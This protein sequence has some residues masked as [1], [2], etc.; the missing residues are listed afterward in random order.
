VRTTGEIGGILLRRVERVRKA[1]R[2]EFVCGLRAV[3][4]AR[5]DLE[6][7]ARLAAPY[8]AAAADLPAILDAQRTQLKDSTART[9]ALE[10]ELDERRARELYEAAHPD[11]SGVRQVRLVDEP[12]WTME[13]LRGLAQAVTAWPRV[14]FLGVLSAPPSVLLATSEDSGIDAGGV[15]RQALM[16][17]G[18]RGGGSPRLAQGT[19]PDLGAVLAALPA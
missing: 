13:R 14:M 15:L 19:A 9:R 17:A 4:R 10:Q 11:G 16:Q 2:L 5:A 7:L 6:L 8:S 18:G 3:R 12:G 1:I